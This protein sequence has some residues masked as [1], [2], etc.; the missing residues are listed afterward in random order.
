[1]S[2]ETGPACFQ[3]AQIG[4]SEVLG[5]QCFDTTAFCAI[6]VCTKHE[7]KAAGHLQ[8]RWKTDLGARRI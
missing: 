3:K 6:V 4:L 1:M 8:N 2:P 7:L 5:E